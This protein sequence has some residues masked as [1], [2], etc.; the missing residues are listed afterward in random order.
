MDPAGRKRLKEQLLRDI[1]AWDRRDP[2]R[3]RDI[4]RNAVDIDKRIL[5]DLMKAFQ[6]DLDEVRSWGAG[7]EVPEDYKR[8][9]I[10][11][12]IRESIERE[13]EA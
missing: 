11:D 12:A 6:T 1:E 10:V 7:T 3:F 13:S 8:T 9:V 5:R 4:V 2:R